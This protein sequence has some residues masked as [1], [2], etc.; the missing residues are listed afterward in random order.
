[1]ANTISISSMRIKR[2]NI[3]M[4]RIM[5]RASMRTMAAIM[6]K[7][8]IKKAVTTRRDI[9]KGDIIR[10]SMARRGK[11]RKVVIITVTRDIRVIRGIRTIGDMM[12]SMRRRQAIN[13]IRNGNIRRDINVLEIT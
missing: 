11:K 13:I 9:I 2:K 10:A 7:N 12:R 6:M 5:M 8:N 4:M 1:M 3:S